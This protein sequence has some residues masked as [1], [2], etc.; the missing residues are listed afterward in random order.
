MKKNKLVCI[1]GMGGAGK[2]IVSDEFVRAG[3]G[4]LR[5][6]QI[7][8]DECIR[9]EDAS[10]KVQKEIRE[11]FR[12]KYGMDAYAI[13]NIPKFNQLLKRGNVV[14]DGL[15]SWSEYKVL[16]QKYKD[17]FFVVTVYASPELRYERLS[18]RFPSKDD[19][20]L[21]NHHHTKKEAKFRDYA[22]IE[23]IEKGGPI[24]MADYLVVNTSDIKNVQEQTKK[25]IEELKT[26]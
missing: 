26:K 15:Y 25:I 19:K 14:G 1:V 3:Y 24:A 21:R 6:G 18:K 5:F 12:K 23:N 4:Y 13:L 11:G 8:L 16:K 20:R 2:S 7:T 10:E 22:E 17:Q 9:R